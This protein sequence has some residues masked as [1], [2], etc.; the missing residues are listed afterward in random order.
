[1]TCGVHLDL[2]DTKFVFHDELDLELDKR[3]ERSSWSKLETEV[4][5]SCGTLIL[6]L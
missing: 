4:R 6:I 5:S 3:V 2:H 1:V